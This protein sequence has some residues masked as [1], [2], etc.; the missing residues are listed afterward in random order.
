[1]SGRIKRISNVRHGSKRNNRLHIL[2]K[3]TLRIRSQDSHSPPMNLQCPSWYRTTAPSLSM[4]FQ[5]ANPTL[6]TEFGGTKICRCGVV[7]LLHPRG[8]IVVLVVVVN[9]LPQRDP[10]SPHYMTVMRYIII[11]SIDRRAVRIA[12]FFSPTAGYHRC[13]YE[14]FNRPLI[15]RSY[16]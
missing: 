9:A 2:K 15:T 7:V 13:L 14:H 1:M 4:S 8:C 5:T 16:L 11:N 12:R 10:W 6:A 3:I